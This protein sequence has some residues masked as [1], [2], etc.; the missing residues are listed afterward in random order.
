MLNAP[1]T[2]R[3]N[4]SRP[5]ALRDGEGATGFGI[6]AEAGGGG[7]GAEEAGDEVRHCGGHVDDCEEEGGG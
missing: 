3:G 5:C 4:S 2:P 1:E 6:Q 7:E